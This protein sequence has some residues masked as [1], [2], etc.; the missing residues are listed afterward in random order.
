MLSVVVVR[1]RKRPWDTHPR[2]FSERERVAIEIE[3]VQTSSAGK[4]QVASGVR[5]VRTAVVF[6]AKDLT[7][8]PILT[9]R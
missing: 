1:M 2:R 9:A 6:P 8:Q 7:N 4:R 5:C 3:D